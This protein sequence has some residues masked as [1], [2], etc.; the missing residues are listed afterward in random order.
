MKISGIGRMDLSFPLPAQLSERRIRKDAVSV[1][2]LG[3]ASFCLTVPTGHI[4]R[5]CNNYEP[6][7]SIISSFERK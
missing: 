2:V 7:G 6:L 3:E 5:T 1:R 4:H